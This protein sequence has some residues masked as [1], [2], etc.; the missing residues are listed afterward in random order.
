MRAAARRAGDAWRPAVGSL[1]G[2][3]RF[4][5]EWYMAHAWQIFSSAAALESRGPLAAPGNAG[6][7][8]S[9]LPT[10]IL[11]TV[12][13]SMVQEEFRRTNQELPLTRAGNCLSLCDLWFFAVKILI[14]NS[15]W[16]GI[17]G[18]SLFA[19]FSEPSGVT[20][21]FFQKNPLCL[22]D[23]TLSYE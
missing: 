12:T 7:L 20:H 14:L 4:L 21:N 1:L 23:P 3:S 2:A 15:R 13:A 5:A 22:K 9:L 18:R 6:A 10:L 16:P 11:Y 8:G 17:V 19:A